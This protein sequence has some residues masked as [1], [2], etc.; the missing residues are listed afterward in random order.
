MFKGAWFSLYFR[1]LSTFNVEEASQIMNLLLLLLWLPILHE[2]EV[3]LPHILLT[4]LA[5]GETANMSFTSNIR[6]TLFAPTTEVE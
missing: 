5:V 4:V 2:A 3:I 1:F 6:V